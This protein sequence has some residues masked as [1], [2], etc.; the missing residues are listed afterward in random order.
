MTDPCE[1]VGVKA[2]SRRHAV[3]GSVAAYVATL[4]YVSGRTA[5]CW[6]L[7][8]ILFP[9]C[10]LCVPSVARVIDCVKIRGFAEDRSLF[11]GYLVGQIFLITEITTLG[12]LLYVR[13]Y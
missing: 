5:W 13:C 9:L 2:A 11:T 1:H 3:P 10:S 6:R 7:L 4:A 12:T 8:E